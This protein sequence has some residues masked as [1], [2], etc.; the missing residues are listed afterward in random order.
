MSTVELIEEFCAI[1]LTAKKARNKERG[2]NHSS[3]NEAVFR[4]ILINEMIISNRG[5]SAHYL[6]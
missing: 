1:R 2:E 5:E 4:L 3:P 6:H